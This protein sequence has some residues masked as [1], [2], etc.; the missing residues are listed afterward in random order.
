MDTRSRSNR[1]NDKPNLYVPP[2][3]RTL[4]FSPIQAA[5][6]ATYNEKSNL[7]R[8]KY[9]LTWTEKI[10]EEKAQ[11]DPYNQKSA[12]SPGSLDDAI[13]SATSTISTHSMLRVKNGVKCD[14]PCGL[15]HQSSQL[16]NVG[17]CDHYL[18]KA[19]SGIVINSDGSTG[20]SNW[21]C[22]RGAFTWLPSELCKKF[23]TEYVITQQQTKKR[24]HPCCRALTKML[25]KQEIEA[26]VRTGIQENTKR[27]IKKLISLTGSEKRQTRT[28]KPSI[29]IRLAVID[30]GPRD[31]L[32]IKHIAIPGIPSTTIKE[33]VDQLGDPMVKR[34][35]LFVMRRIEKKFELSFSTPFKEFQKKRL[36][37]L[38]IHESNIYLAIDLTGKIHS[39][40]EKS[41]K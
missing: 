1:D 25:S 28:P 14:G 37:E 27:A 22:Y 40:D 35:R 38:P 23:Y 7:T 20:C 32:K 24:L 4:V 11:A 33:I 29:Q 6:T 9:E 36:D 34:G 12:L 31:S 2:V 10:D 41:S 13:S 3:L 17:R 5:L 21:D 39:C 18:C 8:F 26:D 16:I 15:F 30:H 19:C